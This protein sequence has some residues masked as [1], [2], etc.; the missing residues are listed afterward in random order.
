MTGAGKPI[1][2]VGRAKRL[3][4][5]RIAE[6]ELLGFIWGNGWAA[7]LAHALGAQGRVVTR[8]HE[9][10]LPGTAWPRPL[11]IAFGSDF[12]AGPTT[13]PDLLASA[14]DALA[15]IRP[16][17]LLLGGDF[18]SHHA[19]HVDQLAPLL[20]RIPVPFGRYAVL[21]N[22]DLWADDHYI[23]RQLEAAGVTLLTNR[24]VRLPAPFA[25]VWL[26]GLD[27]ALFG[28]PDAKAAL[29][30]AQG[31]RIILMHSPDGLLNLGAERFELALCGHTHGGQVTL[32]GGGAIFV[33]AGKLSRRYAHGEH[34]VG[35]NGDAWLLVSRGVGCT[36]LP[37]R[38][39][40]APEVHVVNVQRSAASG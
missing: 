1:A 11:R 27:E 24:N 23:V 4:I 36:T 32:P 8:E 6:E 38:L 17:V 33:P 3:T 22:H 26:C 31:T 40:A 19:R 37:V 9:V 28:E 15:A 7:R 10:T 21:G 34:D 2:R 18:V 29:A 25:D 20:G 16:D 14:C 12:H 35:R 30:G 5:F 39:G 13:H